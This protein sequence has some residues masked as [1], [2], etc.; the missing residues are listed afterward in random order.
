[1]RRLSR[2]LGQDAGICPW[3]PLVDDGERERALAVRRTIALA[4]RYSPWKANCY[5]Q[6]I[7]ARLLLGLYGVPYAIHF[8]LKRMPEGDGHDAHAWVVSGPVA[9]TGGHSFGAYTVVRTF[10]PRRLRTPGNRVGA[11]QINP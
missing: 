9:V 5:P 8:G 4:A 2:L 1:M 11:N 7:T 6:A 3:V 10:V